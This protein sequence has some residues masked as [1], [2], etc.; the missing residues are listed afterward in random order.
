MM[1]ENDYLFLSLFLED[2][3]SIFDDKVFNVKY[4]AVKGI[5]NLFEAFNFCNSPKEKQE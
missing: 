5:T 1:K 2:Y 4:V 3:K